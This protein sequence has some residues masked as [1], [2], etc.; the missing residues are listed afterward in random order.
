MYLHNY[1][2]KWLNRRDDD[3]GVIY[4]VKDQVGLHT[5]KMLYLG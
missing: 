1:D 2:C 4:T 3:D 5:G